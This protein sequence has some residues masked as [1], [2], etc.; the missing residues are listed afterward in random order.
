VKP[1]Y[2]ILVLDAMTG[3]SSLDVARTFDNQIGFSG[4]I[5]TKMDSDTRGGA[6]FA[7]RYMLQKSILFVGSGEGVD[8]I[9]LF[10]PKRMA[11]RMLG[12]GDLMTLVEQAEEK[13][14]QSEKEQLEKAVK[15][16]KITLEDFRKQLEMVSRMGSFSNIMQYMPGASKMN[17][18]DDTI[19]KGE[20]EM[21]QFSAIMNSMTRKERV[22]PKLLNSSR[23]QRIARGAGVTQKSIDHLLK[24]FRESQQMLKSLKKMG[25]LQNL[26]K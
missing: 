15:N 26:F 16:G 6:A 1:Q 19:E 18:S 25:G 24:R 13:V 22:E 5:L 3:Q 9:E 21:K 10:R 7:F 20:Q 17:V 12:M 2:K 8:Q 14:K 11:Q 4:A 23:K